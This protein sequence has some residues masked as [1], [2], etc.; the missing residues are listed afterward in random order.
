MKKKQKKNLDLAIKAQQKYDK[1]YCFF[2]HF[3]NLKDQLYAICPKENHLKLDNDKFI[4]EADKEY[5]LKKII[6]TIL[7]RIDEEM[8]DQQKIVKNNI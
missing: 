8:I 5:S 2:N 1:L 3:D 6:Y 7:E 4:F